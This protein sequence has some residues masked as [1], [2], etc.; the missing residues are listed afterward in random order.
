MTDGQPTQETIQAH[1]TALQGLDQ[2]HH[3]HPF[4][5][6]NTLKQAPPFLID[7]AEGCYVSGQGIRLLDMMAG[8]ACVNIGYGNPEMAETAAIAY[9]TLSYYHSFAAV[10]NPAVAALCGKIASLAPANF[11]SVFLSNSGSEANETAIKVAHMYW[12]LK[13]KKSKRVIIA[14]DNSYHGSSIVTAALTGNKAMQE[15]FGI[16]V[17]QDIRHAMMPCWF[18]LG[19][20]MALDEF[21]IKAAQ[22]IEEQILEAGPD[23]VAAFIGEPIQNA[24]GAVIPPETYWPEVQRICKKYDVLLILD[25]VVTGFGRAGAWFMAEEYNIKPDIITLAKGL[26]SAYVPIAA[27]IVSDEIASFLEANAGVI[28]HGFT[29]SAH[30][31]TCAI[32][33]KNIEILERE[34]LVERVRDHIGPYFKQRLKILE[35]HPLVGEVR[36]IGLMAGIELVKDKANREQYP[37]E[38]MVCNHVSQSALMKGLIVR[39]A[40]N[41]LI[42]CPPFI[43]SEQE[44]DLTVQALNECLSDTYQALQQM[45]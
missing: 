33:L 45:G 2:K 30:P 20:D 19:G 18:R 31:V 3:M 41:A 13:G 21:G 37:L 12:Q 7:S 4:T 32:A 10:S 17:G 38:G 42:L 25:E 43:V 6:P 15:P 11:N 34:K 9:K 26:S 29:T 16:E 27:T 8:L 36:S 24:L 5:D 40:G 23:N 28:Q 44:I 39:P 22:S 1:L 14:R 35:S